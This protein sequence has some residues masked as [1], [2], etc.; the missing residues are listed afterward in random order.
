MR[1][2]AWLTRSRLA[3]SE[4]RIAAQLVEFVAQARH[5]SAHV[6]SNCAADAARTVDER[7]NAIERDRNG[8]RA[9]RAH[10]PYHSVADAGSNR[11]F[12]SHRRVQ[13]SSR[14]ASGTAGIATGADGTT[15]DQAKNCRAPQ[16][17][18][19]VLDRSGAAA[20]VC[21]PAARGRHRARTHGLELQPSVAAR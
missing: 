5:R 13:P 19:E 16:L 21:R 18:P 12:R 17:G 3:A 8:A 2:I 20:N 6:M 14:C 7:C 10:H 15:G 4:A 1:S 11:H 9:D